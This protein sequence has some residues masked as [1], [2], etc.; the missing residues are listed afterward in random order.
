M[1]T[2]PKKK[3]HPSKVSRKKTRSHQRKTAVPASVASI[4]LRLYSYIFLAVILV[5]GLTI[6]GYACW[7]PTGHTP[8]DTSDTP[9]GVAQNGNNRE[10]ETQT[11][12][13][14]SGTM[15]KI[16]SS[17]DASTTNLDSTGNSNGNPVSGAS[18]EPPSA[19]RLV[20]YYVPGKNHQQPFI[21]Q[22]ARELMAKYNGIY[23]GSPDAKR[24]YLTFDAGYEMGYT[25]TILDTLAQYQVKAA[26][27]V[28]KP[29]I[30]S[31]PELV[32]RMVAEGHVVGSHTATHPDLTTI[33]EEKIDKE[34]ETTEAAFLAATR[35]PLAR[36]VRPPNG[37]YSEKVLATLHSLNYRPVF[38]SMAFR[39]WDVKNQPT[40]AKIF[41]DVT[42]NIHPGAVILLH[43]VSSSNAQALPNIIVELKK[44][45]YEFAPLSD[46]LQ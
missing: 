30:T 5:F 25:A 3:A 37:T 41:Q 40:P 39:D 17:S 45:G 38:W 4:R 42:G 28:T 23:L 2:R 22:S 9:S 46:F 7:Y 19:K 21:P 6:G 26:F 8:S 13:L 1:S 32:K 44:Q 11:N 34:L 43:N 18:E 15:P 12:S 24:I 16:S 27:F 35:Q 29:F 14:P 31:H 36:L 20:W 33:S 10:T